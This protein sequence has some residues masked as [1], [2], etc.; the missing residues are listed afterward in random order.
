ME[1]RDDTI[2]L[3]SNINEIFATTEITQYF[4]NLLDNSIEL[5]ISFPIKEEINITKFIVTMDEKVFISKVI[6]KE[7]AEEKYND[8]IASGN[9]A[10][11]SNYDDNM[12]DYM[13]NIGNI[14]PKQKIKLNTIFIQMIGSQ[15]MSYEF[16]IMEKYPTFHY[17]EINENEPKNKII[18]ANFIIEAQSKITRL[19]A[20]FFDDEAKKNSTYDVEFSNDFKKAN[21]KY[22]KN[23]ESKN[24]NNYLYENQKTILSSFCLLFRTVNMNNPILYYQ[25]N[26]EY[27][28]TS[29]SINYVYPSKEMKT[30]PIPNEPDQDNKISY[31]IKYHKDIINESPGLFIF[32][33]DQSGSMSG[34]AINLVKET[35]L[36][37]INTLKSGSYFQLI[38]FGSTFKK[39]NEEPVECNPENVK[40]IIDIING[41]KA[42]L[43]GTNICTPLNEIY[44]N[45]NNYSKFNL[46]KNIFLLTDGEVED[47]E[48][49]IDLITT[50]SNKFRIHAFGIGNS[51]DKI[52]IERSGKLG[53][54]SSSFIEN[55][56]QIKSAVM[57]TLNKYLRP[58]ISDINFNFKNYQNNNKNS[59]IICKPVNNF[60]YQDEIM[61]YSFILD[62]KNKIDIDNLPE[63]I[64]V[65]I[66]GKEQNNIIKENIIFK[67]NINIIKIK[68]GDEMTKMIVGKALKNNKDLL[69]DEKKEIEFA[70]KY[71]IL[72]KNTSLYSEALND[73][74][75]K[76]ELIKVNLK[77]NINKIETSNIGNFNSKRHRR[78]KNDSFSSNFICQCGKSFLSQPAL[79]N[80]IKTKHPE[81]FMNFPKRGRGRCRKYPTNSNLSD[82]GFNTFFDKEGRKPE[83]EG[84]NDILPLAQ[85][86]L[87]F[88]YESTYSDKLFSKPKTVQENIILK[89]LINKENIS[90]KLKNEKYCDDIFYE[91]L[92]TFMNKTNK[93]YF[94]FMVKYILLLR[95]FYNI[96]KN[97]DKKEE[98]KKEITNTVLPDELPDISNE[99]Y[100]FMESNNFFGIENQQ[101]EIVDIIQHF[102]IWLFNNEYTKSKLSLAS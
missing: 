81:T 68:D 14:A 41:L 88:I 60:T 45:K 102:C 35:L 3:T 85:S 87:K 17:Q 25:Y 48:K 61:N 94:S 7:K 86:I 76:K 82:F 13:V 74:S 40:K 98:D 5:S 27:K 72:S 66:E 50:N 15:D 80:H 52:L 83:N 43:G 84:N 51:F 78:S 46:S 23:P 70:I 32:L 93:N 75:E 91:Y 21:I 59:I 67:N 20:P 65:E 28:E 92:V 47:R 96:F 39:Y 101:N 12:T 31:Y 9:I 18:K 8:T 97:K 90:N 24:I 54:G 11:I 38:G 4:T 29:Y 6:H 99:F 71:Q 26:P 22:I 95:E 16:D 49:C 36:E 69:E 89:N 64:N 42:D 57:T 58:Y 79:N 100:M 56:E 1:D 44:S 34:K 33:I 73:N 19:I 63:P 62:E 77:N 2:Y 37:V 30:I 55:V 10:L 53:K